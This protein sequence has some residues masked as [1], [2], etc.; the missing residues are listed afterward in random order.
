MRAKL[1]CISLATAIA[2]SLAACEQQAPDA[3]SQPAEPP[4]PAPTSTASAPAPEEPGKAT[5]PAALQGRWGMT[6]ADCTSTRGDAKGLLRI[7]PTALEFYESVGRLSGIEERGDS[8]IRARF[9]FTG[10]GMTW[11]REQTLA[12]SGDTLTRTEPEGEGQPGGTYTYTRCA[13]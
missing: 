3:G 9:D 1:P 13:A 10:E 2:M 6:P 8:S 12:A 5:I 7:S 4:P 11:S